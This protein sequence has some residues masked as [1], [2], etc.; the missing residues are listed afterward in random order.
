MKQEK[1]QELIRN[2]PAYTDKYFLR[3]KQIL[4]A[5][6]INPT[7]RYQVFARQN[8]KKL[9]GVNEAVDFIK[10]TSPNAKIYALK[11]GMGYKANTP[12][13]KIEAKVQELV[14]LETVYLGILSGNFTGPLDLNEMREKA[15]AIK[16]AAEDKPNERGRR[17]EFLL[18]AHWR[19]L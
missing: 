11:D 5:E 8:I 2:Y 7:V 10:Q 18:L 4:E 15:R 1:I 17:D 12:L 3:T 19:E 9:T 13:I 6:K 16:Q 14:D